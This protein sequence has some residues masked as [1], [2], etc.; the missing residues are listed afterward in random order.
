MNTYETEPAIERTKGCRIRAQARERLLNSVGSG[1]EMD[2]LWF[3]IRAHQGYPFKTVRNLVFTYT[4][5]GNELFI[6]R[7]KKSVTRSSVEIALRRILE[8][9]GIV[10]GPKKI[11]VFGASYLYPMFITFGLIKCE[12]TSS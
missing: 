2:A 12:K 7:K 4:V 8:M 1:S 3:C 10:N 9:E 11:G 5:R 6:D